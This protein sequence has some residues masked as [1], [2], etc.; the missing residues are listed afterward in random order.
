MSTK[1]AGGAGVMGVLFG[2]VGGLLP[3]MLDFPATG[4]PAAEIMEFT[5]S[6]RTELLVAMLFNSSAV[7]LWL[8]FGAGVWLRLHETI[9]GER[10]TSACFVFGFIAFEALLFAGFVPAFLLAYRAPEVSEPRLLYDAAFGLLAMSGAPTAVALGA[11]AAFVLRTRQL[12]RWTAELALLGA[13]AH[14]LLFASF[15]VKDGFFS[16]QG[17]VIVAIPATLFVWIFGT[18]IALMRASPSS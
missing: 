12:P 8:V 14:I 1:I 2:A 17:E 7:T 9:G 18:G 5:N 4:A 15:L 13:A 6:H 11:Y 10:L 16:L 3:N